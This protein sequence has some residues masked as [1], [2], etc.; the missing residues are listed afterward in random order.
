MKGQVAQ[1]LQAAFLHIAVIETFYDIL[2]QFPILMTEDI[3]H[4]IRRVLTVMIRRALILARAGL[5]FG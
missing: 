1:V 5:I 3:C 4:L 2:P